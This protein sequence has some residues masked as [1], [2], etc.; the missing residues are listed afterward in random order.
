MAVISIR[1]ILAIFD[2]VTNKVTDKDAGERSKLQPMEERAFFCRS[3]GQSRAMGENVVLGLFLGLTILSW[4]GLW[5]FM[6]KVAQ[7]SSPASSR[8]VPPVGRRGTGGERRSQLAG[9]DA[10]ATPGWLERWP[11]ARLV[12]GNLLVLGGLLSLTLLGGEVYYRFL[13]D[14][15]DS[16][17]F[18]KVSQRWHVRYWHENKDGLRDDMDY[19]LAIEPGKRRVTFVGDSF[20]AAHGVKDVEN[21]FVNLVRKAHPE[22]EVQMLAKPGW[23]TDD[24]IDFLGAS[25]TN[26]YQLDEVVLV[27]CLNDVSDLMPARFEGIQR[28]VEDLTHS[29]WLRR[30]SFLVNT[31]YHRIKMRREPFMRSYYGF[32]KEAY[33]G[34]LWET[35]KQRLKKL[36][37]LVEG[38]GGHLLVVTFPFLHALGPGYEYQFVH[39]ELG[40]WWRDLKVPH[41]DLLK[42]YQDLPP[43]KVTVNRF[44][45]HPNEYAHRLA[46]EAIDTFLGKEMTGKKLEAR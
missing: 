35:Q 5:V 30:N 46:A 14:T 29:G 3:F 1:A 16:L 28:I 21:R 45:A 19:S 43:K 40:Q 39:E 12:L 22:W 11:G 4:G 7:T 8:G 15:T 34:P 31:V 44:D 18:T 38:H 24:E 13:T 20:T 26:G 25:I 23:D 42:V 33:R 9:E 36:R 6:R 10:C 37:G 32:V 27:Y 41:L 17:L 2:Q